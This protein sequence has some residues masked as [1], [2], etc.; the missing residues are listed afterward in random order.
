M[1]AP[2]HERTGV[3][4][5]RKKVEM[6][7]ERVGRVFATSTSNGLNLISGCSFDCERFLVVVIKS[8]VY[9][10]RYLRITMPLFL[11]STI[12][13]NAFTLPHFTCLLCLNTYHK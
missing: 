11:V 10:E 2:I 12:L 5:R 13:W 6:E 7:E 4:G 1:N 3:I 9:K 8:I